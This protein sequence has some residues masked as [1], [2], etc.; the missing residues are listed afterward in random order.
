MI[1]EFLDISWNII[2]GTTII[3]LLST[4]KALTFT[5]TNKIFTR[6]VFFIVLINKKI[7]QS[8]IIFMYKI[9]D[10]KYTFTYLWWKFT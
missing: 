9:K 10:F 4:I 1:V 6:I 8:V 3:L 5:K 7:L 2:Y